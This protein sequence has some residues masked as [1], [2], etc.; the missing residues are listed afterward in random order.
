[1][2][3][4]GNNRTTLLILLRFVAVFEIGGGRFVQDLCARARLAG[5]ATCAIKNDSMINYEL[6][7]END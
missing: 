1:M 7:F 6:L 4:L 3:L 5:G 2:A